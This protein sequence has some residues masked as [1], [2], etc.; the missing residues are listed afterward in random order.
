MKNFI[1]LILVFMAGVAYSQDCRPFPRE[2][3]RLE[4]DRMRALRSDRAIFDRSVGIIRNHCLTVEQVVGLADLFRGDDLRLLF[5]RDAFMNVLNPQDYFE[6]LDTFSKFSAA[7]KLYDFMLT[8]GS[9]I[10]VGP[11]LEEV[12]VC[13][14][15]DAELKAILATLQKENFPMRRLPIATSMTKNRCLSV[16]QIRKVVDLLSI[17]DDK[18]NLVKSTYDNCPNQLDY[19]QLVDAMTFQAEKDELLRFIQSKQ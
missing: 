2:E 6:V 7:F 8:M 10:N 17:G 13:H 4:L 12:S 14:T 1:A 18:L 15:T 3:F 19:H 9:P 5:A 16:G 11:P